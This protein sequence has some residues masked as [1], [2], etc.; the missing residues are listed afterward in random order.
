[1]SR[2]HVYA[3]STEH[4]ETNMINMELKLCLYKRGK[5]GLRIEKLLKQFITLDFMIHVGAFLK[6]SAAT[7][8]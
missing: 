6:H 3:K 7:P 4:N 8:P 5:G 1:M 2:S